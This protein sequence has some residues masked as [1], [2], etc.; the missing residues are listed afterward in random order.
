V[1][2]AEAAS[3][4]FLDVYSVASSILIFPTGSLCGEDIVPVEATALLWPQN[5]THF[6]VC[7]SLTIGIYMIVAEL[8]MGPSMIQDRPSGQNGYGLEIRPKAVELPPHGENNRLLCISKIV[9]QI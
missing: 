4:D 1:S 8:T 6:N 9:L 2:R 5:N 7:Q 3:R